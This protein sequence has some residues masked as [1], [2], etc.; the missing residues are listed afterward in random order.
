[1]CTWSTSRRRASRPLLKTVGWF[2]M[3]CLASTGGESHSEAGPRRFVTLKPG[4]TLPSG[5]TCAQLVRRSPWEPRPQNSDAN[6]TEGITGVKVDG[7]GDR[8]NFTYAGRI[9][10]KFTGTTDEIIQWGACKWGF[11]E[12]IT[13]ARAVQESYWRQSAVGDETMDAEA[14]AIIG[15]EAPCW[16]SY[17]IFQIKGTVHE[18]TYPASANS[19]SFNVDYSLAWLRACYEGAFGHWLGNG[20]QADDEWGCVG[21]SFSGDWYDSEGE[22]YIRRVKEHWANRDWE[23]AGF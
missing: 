18:G 20:Y 22:K 8:F 7:A 3:A 2:A 16:Q 15:K 12:D 11:S 19:T 1:M 21:A 4:S 9:D 6:H 10:G 5:L 14:C 23:Q 13:R 17:G